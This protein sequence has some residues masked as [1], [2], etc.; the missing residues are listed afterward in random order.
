MRRYINSIYQFMTM[1]NS[2]EE[3]FEH[4]HSSI[5]E[6]APKFDGVASIL[7]TAVVVIMIIASVL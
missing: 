3:D 7:A 4:E 6:S 1:D 2:H 5:E